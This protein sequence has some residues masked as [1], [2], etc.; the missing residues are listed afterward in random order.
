MTP[1]LNLRSLLRLTP[2]LRLPG[3][4]ASGL[5]LLLGHLLLRPLGHRLLNRLGL[6]RGRA[7]AGRLGLNDLRNHLGRLGR[8]LSG[9]RL[10]GFDGLAG[11]RAA[12]SHGSLGIFRGSR[13]CL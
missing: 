2:L 12:D 1:L 7:T 11:G 10:G 8:G 13:E 9:H 4:R 3:L 5:E 6:G